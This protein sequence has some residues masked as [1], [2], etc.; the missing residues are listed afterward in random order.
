[1]SRQQ[2]VRIGDLLVQKGLIREDQLTKA[3]DEQ[4]RS[5]KKIGKAIV[6]LGLVTEGQ[7]LRALADHFGYPYVDLI[8]F[9]LKNDLVLSL[10]ETQARRYRAIILSE[11]PDGYLVGMVEPLDLLAVDELQRSLK[12]P[13]HPA[14]V[15]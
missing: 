11:Q 9:K 12:R 5:G 13:V 3:L 8:R 15:K 4:N 1:M 7:L 10:P 14:Y 2:K 6:D